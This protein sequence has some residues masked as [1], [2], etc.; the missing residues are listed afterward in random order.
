VARAPVDET[1]APDFLSYIDAEFA[2]LQ[3]LTEATMS[4]PRFAP[5]LDPACAPREAAKLRQ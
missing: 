5:V 4:E 1:T 3:A 2:P